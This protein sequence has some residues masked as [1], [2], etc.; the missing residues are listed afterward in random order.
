MP[1]ATLQIIGDVLA[2]LPP[3]GW[4]LV[5]LLAWPGGTYIGQTRQP[6]AK[7]WAQ[8]LDDLRKGRHPNDALRGAWARYGAAGIAGTIL[9]VVPLT[10]LDERE[11]YWIEQ[12]GS[13]NEAR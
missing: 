13:A 7:R 10:R 8:H 2:H 5:Y 3:R 9:E 1:A 11:R 12:Y 4:G 6:L